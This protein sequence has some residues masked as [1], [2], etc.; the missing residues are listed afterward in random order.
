MK[1][2]VQPF[3]KIKWQKSRKFI[4]ENRRYPEICRTSQW[5]SIQSGAWTLHKK[6]EQPHVNDFLWWT[7]KKCEC[8]KL[9]Q[10]G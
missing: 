3:K 1:R 9:E 6:P 2:K 10:N 7:G 5:T 8:K 4:K